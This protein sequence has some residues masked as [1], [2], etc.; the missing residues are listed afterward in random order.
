MLRIG[1][2]GAGDAGRHHARALA[3][4]HAA[5]ELAW[6]AVGSR[7]PATLL[8]RRGELGMPEDAAGVTTDELLT[9]LRCDAVIVATPDGLHHEHALRALGAGKHVLVE[10]PLAISL[11]HASDLVAAART[12]DRALQ[13]GYHLRHHAGHE[14]V[15]EQLE[16]LVGTLRTID[17]RWAW[18]DPAVAGWR[19]CG[20]GARWWAMAALGTHAID[21]ALWFAGAA[22]TETACLRE[23]AQG[24]DRA[25][26][27]ILRF[28]TGVLARLSVAVTHRARPTLTLIGDRGELECQDT[29]GARGAGTLV[30]RVKHETW[31][32][33]FVAE[34]PYLRQLRA[35]VA[36]CAGEGS[37]IDAQAI[38]NV[39]L[40]HRLAPP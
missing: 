33:H 30:H 7:D 38:A 15:R 14:L 20:D 16:G 31:D 19:A 4:A 36:R 22:V 12:S 6:T 24:M 9:G 3:A 29:L 23:P 11:V 40:L 37:R 25:C 5:G 2:L 13:A 39:E 34:D 1:L 32:L 21:L 18:P 26:E 17:V 27:A 28:S 10:K 8:A 35:F